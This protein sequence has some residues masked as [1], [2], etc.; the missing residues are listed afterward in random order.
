MY[1][2]CV[3]FFE[4]II[5]KRIFYEWYSRTGFFTNSGRRDV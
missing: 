5:T 2:I 4:K 1:F 3:T